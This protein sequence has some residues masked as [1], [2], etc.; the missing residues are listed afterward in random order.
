MVLIE[1]IQEQLHVL[2]PEKQTEV[3]DFILFLQQRVAI[4]P[5]T[6]PRSLKK[7][8]AFGAWQARQVDALVY[9]QAMRAE[10][11]DE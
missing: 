1:Q 10:W 11:G 5:P 8:P 3:L 7:H 9:Q 4:P 6:K 2:P